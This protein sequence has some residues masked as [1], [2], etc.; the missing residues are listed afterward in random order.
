MQGRHT[1]DVVGGH[2]CQVGHA[3]R[4]AALL[5]D[6]RNLAQNLL[7]TWVFQAHL[8]QEAAVDLVDQLQMAG[9]QGAEQLEP[10]LLQGFR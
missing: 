4:L 1:V 6:N 7:I 3:H 8:L 5:V 10:P 2:G 9:Q